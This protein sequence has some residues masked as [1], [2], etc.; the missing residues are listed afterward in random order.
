MFTD[1]SLSKAKINL[2]PR[3]FCGIVYQLPEQ[4]P[5][6]V[7]QSGITMEQKSSTEVSW[8]W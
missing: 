2:A 8:C 7:N 5:C 4:L 6:Y 1:A 3:N